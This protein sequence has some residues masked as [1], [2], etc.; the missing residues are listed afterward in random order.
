MGSVLVLS[1]MV[2]YPFPSA[3]T[4]AVVDCSTEKLRRLYSI[5]TPK[6]DTSVCQLPSCVVQRHIIQTKLYLAPSPEA[7][8]V[9]RHALRC[10]G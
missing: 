2:A 4:E 7:L 10:Q 5:S 8:P 9:G 1:L 3:A 6:D